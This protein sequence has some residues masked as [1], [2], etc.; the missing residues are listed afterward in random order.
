MKTQRNNYYI[1]ERVHV[2]RHPYMVCDE[3]IPKHNPADDEKTI[4]KI[5]WELFSVTNS[6]TPLKNVV[7]VSNNILW[8]V[9]EILRKTHSIFQ[10]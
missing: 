5:S 2:R 6:L 9:T 7:S 4:T 1:V 10:L 8:C 3:K